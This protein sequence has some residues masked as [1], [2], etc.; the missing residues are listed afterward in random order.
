MEKFVKRC[1]FEWFCL[2]VVWFGQ[3]YRFRWPIRG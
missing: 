1:V 2:T 3:I